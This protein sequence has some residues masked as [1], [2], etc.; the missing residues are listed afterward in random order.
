MTRDARAFTAANLARY[1][2]VVL[3]NTIGDVLDPA[4]QAA[5]EGHVTGVVEGDCGATVIGNC[6]K[7][8][9]NDEPASRCP[10]RSCPTGGSC[11]TTTA[12]RSASSTRRPAPA[13]VCQHDEDVHHQRRLHGEAHRGRLQRHDGGAH[14]HRHGRRHRAG[15]HRR[16]AGRGLVLHVGRRRAVH[17]H[18]PG[19][20]TRRLFAGDGKFRARPRQPRPRPRVHDRLHGCRASRPPS[21]VTPAAGST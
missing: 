11:T 10:S 2:A 20:R 19:G 15:G 4:R 12:A 21:A 3:L 14:P 6:E 9:H 17:G 16:R 18:R 7:V 8:T 5:F 1:R 13:P